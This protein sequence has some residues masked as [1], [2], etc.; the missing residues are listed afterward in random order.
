MFP[1]TTFTLATKSIAKHTQTHMC[2]HTHTQSNAKFTDGVAL[3][4][5]QLIRSY[6]VK[7]SSYLLAGFWS[8][9]IGWSVVC[10]PLHGR[11]MKAI[12]VSI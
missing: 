2:R 8:N 11:Q 5:G 9:V 12:S 7:V 10:R 4:K 3:G 1:L 6:R